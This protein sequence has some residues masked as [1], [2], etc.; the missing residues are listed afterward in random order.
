[1]SILM[2]IF[3]FVCLPRPSYLNINMPSTSPHPTTFTPTPVAPSPHPIDP[4][5]NNMPSTSGG[6]LTSSFAPPSTVAWKCPEWLSHDSGLKQFNGI[7]RPHV[8]RKMIDDIE[9][10]VNRRASGIHNFSLVEQN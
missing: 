2:V 10:Y 6:Q 7:E 4:Y 3:S 1:M 9:L 8:K 5:S